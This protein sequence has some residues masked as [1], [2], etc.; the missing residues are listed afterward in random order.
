MSSAISSGASRSALPNTDDLNSSF[1]DFRKDKN[2]KNSDERLDS[3][4]GPGFVYLD[5]GQ[6]WHSSPNIQ[7]TRGFETSIIDQ[8]EEVWDD[9]V[10]TETVSLPVIDPPSKIDQFPS[11]SVTP[12]QRTNDAAIFLLEKL[13]TLFRKKQISDEQYK[14]RINS[15]QSRFGRPESGSSE[16]R[17]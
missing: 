17:V 7:I 13:D 14:V 16:S 5:T 9:L 2:E 12:H 11:P 4:A 1:P 6:P 3:V 10:N 15:I 8:V